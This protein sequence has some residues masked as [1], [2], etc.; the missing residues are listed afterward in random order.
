MEWPLYFVSKKRII[1][2]PLLFLK[3]FTLK[4]D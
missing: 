2:A 1:N 3:N 4:S